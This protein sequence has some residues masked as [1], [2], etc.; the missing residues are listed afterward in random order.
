MER[1]REFL[2]PFVLRSLE[3]E[4][5][6]AFKDYKTLLQEILNDTPAP[7]IAESLPDQQ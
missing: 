2:M 1:T 4:E 3:N 6:P 5:K 7:Q